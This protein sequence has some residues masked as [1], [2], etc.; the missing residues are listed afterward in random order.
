MFVLGG[1]RLLAERFA[2]YRT[3]RQARSVAHGEPPLPAAIVIRGNAHGLSQE[4]RGRARR[5]GPVGEDRPFLHG[6]HE[7]HATAMPRDLRRTSSA[8]PK[9][10]YLL[11]A[12]GNHSLL[13][14]LQALDAAGK[15]GVVWHRV[16]RR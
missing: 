7:S 5:E 3:A 2:D 10:Q 4:V 9:L 14:V 1:V 6:K 12:D 16:H 15:D 11:Y 8:W 13:V